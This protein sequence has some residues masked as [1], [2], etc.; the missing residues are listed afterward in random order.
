MADEYIVWA[1]GESNG[2]S[3]FM[4]LPIQADELPGSLAMIRMTTGPGISARCHCLGSIIG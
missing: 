1:E 4:L 2:N 3:T